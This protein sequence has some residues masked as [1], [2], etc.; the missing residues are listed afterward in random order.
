MKLSPPTVGVCAAFL[1]LS[2]GLFAQTASPSPSG[3]PAAAAKP[4][5]TPSPFAEL[6]LAQEKLSLE[7]GIADQELRK[8]LAKLAAEKQ[9]LELENAVT[10]Q[11]LQA[12]ISS[13]QAEIEKLNK[14]ADLLGKRLAVKDAERR[15]KL[16][17]EL[18]ELREKLEKTRLTTDLAAAEANAAMSA[19]FRE[20]Q[21][22]DQEVQVKTKEL[23]LDRAEFEMQVAKINAQI[24]LREKR[25]QWKNRVDRDIAYT[26]EPFKNG[27]LTISDRR[28]ALN[29][30]IMMDTADYVVERIDY[31]NNQSPENP[32]FI[33]IDRSPGGSVMAGYKILKAMEGSPAPV[34]VVV[35]SFAASM[36]AGITTLAK[37]SYAYPNAIILHHQM[38]SGAF[39]NVT[40]QKE[41]IKDIEEWWNRLAAPVAKK[42]GISLDEFIKEMYRNRSTGDWREFADKARK[43]KW[44]DEVAE[45]IRE[46]SLVKNPDTA[47]APYRRVSP[48]PL[49]KEEVDPNGKH[50][51]Q[52]PKLAPLDCYYL[53]NPDNYFRMAQ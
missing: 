51:V 39:G 8:T 34:Y 29:D 25:D 22:R 3:S 20:L 42:M 43:L 40:E 18:A 31:F 53:Y 12:E 15:T 1:I 6:K 28:I 30:V 44:V 21:A 9:R 2:H 23:Q 19:K 11:K 52:L 7:N 27:V 35:K 37:R 32:I 33:V 47:G 50:F 26:K 17:A 36:A 41:N 46:E 16:D 5:E 24:D 49:M 4:A 45:T 10:Q 14:Q 38:L 48:F 13:L